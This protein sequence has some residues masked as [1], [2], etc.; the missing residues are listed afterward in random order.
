M[1]DMERVIDGKRFYSYQWYKKKSDANKQ[2]KFLRDT[3]GMKVRVVKSKRVL[4]GTG[5]TLFV[6][7]K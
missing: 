6:S 2:A 5:Y 7:K 4:T 1:P 3:R